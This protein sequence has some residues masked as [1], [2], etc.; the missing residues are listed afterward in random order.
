M[1]GFILNYV[2]KSNKE[3]EDRQEREYREIEKYKAKY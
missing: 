1:L 3:E 2:Y